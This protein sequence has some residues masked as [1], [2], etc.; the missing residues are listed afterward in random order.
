MGEVLPLTRSNSLTWRSSPLPQGERAQKQPPLPAVWADSPRSLCIEGELLAFRQRYLERVQRHRHQPVITDDAD[1]I[2][3]AG[4]AQFFLRALEHRVG[5]AP[6]RQQLC[7]KVVDR[8][9]VR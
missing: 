5:Y 7:R 2:D 9:L 6:R 4:L 8:L 3:H 1:Q